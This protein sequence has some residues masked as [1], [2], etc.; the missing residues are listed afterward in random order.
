MTH[1]TSPPFTFAWQD[2]QRLRSGSRIWIVTDIYRYSASYYYWSSTQDWFRVGA[3][4]LATGG[5]GYFRFGI[6]DARKI[7]KVGVPLPPWREPL[8]YG[9]SVVR[10]PHDGEEKGRY[11]VRV[12]EVHLGPELLAKGPL[13]R[14][15]FWQAGHEP[16]AT[17]EMWQQM[18]AQVQ[19]ETLIETTALAMLG[20]F[21][22]GDVKKAIGK[23]ANV[24]PVLARLVRE[25]RLVQIGKG[26]GTQYRVAPTQ[27]PTRVDW[28]D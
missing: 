4:E 6:D 2:E 1:T 21:S 3:V 26:R 11:V 22:A 28:N 13:L 14:R 16:N 9:I 17:S 23:D 12:T 18:F 25:R 5:I 27:I 15:K 20:Q 19:L 10:S 24:T 8:P 7:L